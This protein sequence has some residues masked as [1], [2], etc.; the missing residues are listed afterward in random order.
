MVYFKLT[1]PNCFVEILDLPEVSIIQLHKFI[2]IPHR[3]QKLDK[4]LLANDD[5]P[6]V[7]IGMEA[8]ARGIQEVF[9]DEEVYL[10][11]LI[12]DEA[13]GGDA[14]GLQAEVFLHASFRGESE[15][16]LVQSLLEVV[17]VHLVHAL[18]DDEVVLV[19]LV[20]PEKQVLAVRGLKLAPVGQRLFDGTQRR[21]KLD[22]EVDAEA[23]Q[24][25]HYLLLPHTQGLVYL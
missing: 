19:A 9:I 25:V 12:V 3:L 22:V 11:V 14:A 7:V 16:A 2:R 24:G 18:E 8:Q 4:V 20:V 5:C 6:R 1:S 17:D 21:V 10:V 13:E 23:E 15:F